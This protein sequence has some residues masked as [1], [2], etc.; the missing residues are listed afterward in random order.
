MATLTHNGQLII[1]AATANP[2]VAAR[3]PATYLTD[4]T[5]A[6]N[7]VK[8]DLVTQK[9]AHGELGNLTPAQQGNLEA[10][11]HWIAQARSTARLAFP[12]QDV[13]LHQEFQ[14]GVNKPH[15][16]GSVLARA[17]LIIA[18]VQ[19]AANLPALQAK[20]WLAA[21]TAAFVAARAAFSTLDVTQQASKG[22]AKDSTTAKNTDAADLYERLLTI[23][24]AANLQWPA[25]NPANAGIRDQFRLNTF[26][27]AEPSA[28][29]KPTPTTPTPPTPPAPPSTTTS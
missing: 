17:D 12:G 20:G 24:N 2:A 22:G 27:P 13:K 29:V 1:A 26:P 7:K 19:N 18:A 14:V 5:N 3:L 8:A 11:Q 21:D 25:T 9:S 6:L 28:P 23:Q 4:T 10:L 15:D 16:L